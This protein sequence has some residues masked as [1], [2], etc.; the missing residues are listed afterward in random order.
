MDEIKKK[1]SILTIA[2]YLFK[3]SQVMDKEINAFAC[4][5]QLENI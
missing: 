1:Q 5:L 3:A 4:I 2:E